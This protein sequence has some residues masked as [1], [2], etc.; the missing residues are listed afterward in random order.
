M[1]IT[2]NL[3]IHKNLDK[4]PNIDI[5]INNDVVK[6]LNNI[7]EDT[8]H[9]RLE[10]SND[11]LKKNNVL[12][13]DHHGKDPNSIDIS[14]GDIAVEIEEIWFDRI[15][16]HRNLM[17]EQLFFPNWEFGNVENIIHKNC[18]I[19]FNGVWQLIFPEEP[20]SWITDY[21]ESEMFDSDD[22]TTGLTTPKV[23]TNIE[24][25]KKDFF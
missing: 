1:I 15:K 7:Q 14:L 2:L 17:F 22:K 16:L 5:W 4:G 18:Y 24:D 11:K 6:K 9:L 12:L 21:L 20:I 23:N 10:L 19:G 13:V 3:K 25:F 8:L